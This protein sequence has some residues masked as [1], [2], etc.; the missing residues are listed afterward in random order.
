M[1]E[2]FT[3]HLHPLP[4]GRVEAYATSQDGQHVLFR[5]GRI[6]GINRQDALERLFDV[7]RAGMEL[8]ADQS[9]LLTVPEA[10]RGCPGV[11]RT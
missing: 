5:G 6:T 9:V 8:T 7:L 4:D 10:Q 2:C 1:K 3:I 11:S